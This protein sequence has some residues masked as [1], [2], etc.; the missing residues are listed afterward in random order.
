V[1]AGEGA[2]VE[3]LHVSLAISAV[4]LLLAASVIGLGARA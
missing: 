2:L 3:G 1:I 4:V